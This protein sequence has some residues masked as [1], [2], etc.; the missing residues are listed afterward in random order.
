MS[1]LLRN[2]RAF[3]KASS[4]RDSTC[5]KPDSRQFFYSPGPSA[6]TRS[7]RAAILACR[8]LVRYVS[9]PGRR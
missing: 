9:R 1:D 6:D 8:Y 3:A 5:A 2:G 7:Q 4:R